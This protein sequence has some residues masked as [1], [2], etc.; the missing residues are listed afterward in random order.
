MFCFTSSTPTE[1]VQD[2]QGKTTDSYPYP[3]I[4][5]LFQENSVPTYILSWTLEWQ[6]LY[7]TKYSKCFP[8]IEISAMIPG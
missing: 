6:G 2:V 1:K 8:Q 4:Q 5:F 7:V 3:S